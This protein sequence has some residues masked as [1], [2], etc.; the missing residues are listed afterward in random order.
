MND[1]ELTFQICIGATEKVATEKYESETDL[2]MRKQLREENSEQLSKHQ[3]ELE[4]LTQTFENRL[5]SLTSKYHANEAALRQQLREDL[6][7]HASAVNKLTMEIATLKADHSK[8]LGLVEKKHNETLTL[9]NDKF[10]ADL[11]QHINRSASIQESLLHQIHELNK[12]PEN[13]RIQKTF[14]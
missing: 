11:D 4:E 3:K 8:E 13:K 2:E 10:R 1:S 7:K 5:S 12:T 14:P 9:I 6:D